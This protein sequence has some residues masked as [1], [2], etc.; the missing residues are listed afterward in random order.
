MEE[1]GER[2]EGK[3]KREEGIHVPERGAEGGVGR[4]SGGGV[5]FHSQVGEGLRSLRDL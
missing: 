2:R 4:G 1:E 5:G 3:E